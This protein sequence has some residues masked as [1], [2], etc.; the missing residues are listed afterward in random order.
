MGWVLACDK[1]NSKNMIRTI[2]EVQ[3][4]DITNWLIGTDLSSCLFSPVRAKVKCCKLWDLSASRNPSSSITASYPQPTD[5]LN[6]LGVGLNPL[7]TCSLH[8]LQLQ[9]TGLHAFMCEV[10]Q[11]LISEGDSQPHLYNKFEF[12]VFLLLDWLPYQVQSA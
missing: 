4:L 2:I 10:S 6:R 7:Q 1:T 9:L 11:G 5:D 12:R 3:E 8:I